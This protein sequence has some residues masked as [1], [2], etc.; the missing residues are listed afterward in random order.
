MLIGYTEELSKRHYA[1]GIQGKVLAGHCLHILH[2]ET[3]AIN[4]I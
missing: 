2:D 4:I 3:E 1:N